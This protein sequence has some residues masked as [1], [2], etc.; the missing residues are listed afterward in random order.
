[1]VAA[2]EG[3]RASVVGSEG[4]RASVVAVRMPVLRWWEW[5]FWGAV[6]YGYVAVGAMTSEGDALWSQALGWCGEGWRLDR[7]GT[8]S[9]NRNICL[10]A[11]EYV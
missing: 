5:L 3:S 2:S 7:R 9:G 6:C 1:M 4:S 11:A 8:L 10:A